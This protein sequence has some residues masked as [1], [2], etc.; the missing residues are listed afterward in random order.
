MQ[1]AETG[2]FKCN[3]R[4]IAPWNY[5]YS[6]DFLAIA[7]NYP[8]PNIMCKYSKIVIAALVAQLFLM[9]HFCKLLNKTHTSYWCLSLLSLWFLCDWGKCSEE[10]LDYKQNKTSQNVSTCTTWV[11]ISIKFETWKL[12]QQAY[13]LTDRWQEINKLNI[14]LH[15]EI[16]PPDLF[17]SHTEKETKEFYS[18][19]FT[20]R[21]ASTT[22]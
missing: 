14:Y 5:Q 6:V 17:Y 21:I 7:R 19:V 18:T 8:V 1:N 13:T 12:I 16:S 22:Q 4:V 3:Q 20:F 2:N 9:M 10:A 11:N 15:E